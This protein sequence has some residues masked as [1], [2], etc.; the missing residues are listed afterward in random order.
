[1]QICGTLREK[2]EYLTV[3]PRPTAF[4]G[5]QLTRPW[6]APFRENPCLLLG[7]KISVFYQPLNTLGMGNVVVRQKKTRP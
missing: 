4:W 3:E 5:K 2:F 6:R 7:F 1:V